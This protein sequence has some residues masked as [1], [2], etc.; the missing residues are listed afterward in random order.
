MPKN[1][2]KPMAS[3]Y[4]QTYECPTCKKRASGRGHLCHPFQGGVPF[5]CEFC[6]KSVDDA[7][8]VCSAMLDHI[9]YICKNCGRLAAYDSNLCEPQLV[10]VD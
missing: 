10:D 4:I 3:D 7:R 9:Q 2:E 5:T 6:N 8:H 1:K